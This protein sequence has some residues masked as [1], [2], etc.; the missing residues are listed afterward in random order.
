MKTRT[1]AQICEEAQKFKAACAKYGFVTESG[2]LDLKNVYEYLEHVWPDWNMVPL[3]R[4]D[5]GILL[6]E[7]RPADKIIALRNDVYEGMC[8]GEQ[9]HLFTAAH[10]LGHMVMHSNLAFARMEADSQFILV[11]YEKE[12]DLFA[13]ALLGFDSPANIKMRSTLEK[14]LNTLKFPGKK[15]PTK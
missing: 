7:T 3:E 13:E 2:S 15:K 12:A 1:K 11:S 14:L 6:G 4:N 10:E 9:E 5:M 8:R